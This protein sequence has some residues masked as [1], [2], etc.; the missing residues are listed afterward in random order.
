MFFDVAR[1]HRSFLMC[2][3]GNIDYLQHLDLGPCHI[4]RFLA[5]GANDPGSSTHPDAKVRVGSFDA[6]L[7]CNFY[8][9]CTFMVVIHV[10]WFKIQVYKY[11]I[12]LHAV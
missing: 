6:T 5:F 3:R 4:L 1:F 12:V 9:Y 7:P 2:I 11:E 10:H 8:D